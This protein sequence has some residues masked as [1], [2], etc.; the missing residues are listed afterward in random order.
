MSAQFAFK[1]FLETSM[2]QIFSFFGQECALLVL[3]K[4]N[5]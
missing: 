2:L 3:C 4:E 5:D 1:I